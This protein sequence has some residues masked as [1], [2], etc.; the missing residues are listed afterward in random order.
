MC[1]GILTALIY[2]AKSPAAG[3]SVVSQTTNSPSQAVLARVPTYLV[4]SPLS[5]YRRFR[6]IARRCVLW[7]D[8]SNRSPA[9]FYQMTTDE[10]LNRI[11]EMLHVLLQQRTVK[12]LYSIAEVAQILGRAEFTVREWARL[13]RI[14]AIR[15]NGRSEHGEWRVSHEELT[16]IQNEGL[17]PDPSR[18]RL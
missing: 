11:E 12:E 3:R 7:N 1:E 2:F 10:R 16:R 18:R 17:L 15:I 5:N 6:L 14:H 9:G 13:S 8:R 4:C